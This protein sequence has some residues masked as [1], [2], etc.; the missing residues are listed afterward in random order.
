M[1]MN[2]EAEK[3]SE[4]DKEANVSLIMHSYDDIFSSFD[5]RSYSERS[6]S[7]DFLDECKRATRE[8]GKE[9]ELRILIPKGFRNF[10]D[11]SKIK[12]RLRDHFKHHFAIEK[13]EIKKIVSEGAGW[14]LI[15]TCFILTTSWLHAIEDPSF[16]MRVLIT[17][18]EPAG[19]FSFWEGL[20]KIF[21][22]T[23]EKSE[24]YLF[25]KKMQDAEINFSEY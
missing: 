2:E 4:M 24:N 3:F 7:I 23:K 15:G 1:I 18:M 10:R 6:I 16:L 14:F 21:I 11:E 25:Y 22:V 9:I 5:P 13:R 19:W 12:K 20:G 17:M 8:K